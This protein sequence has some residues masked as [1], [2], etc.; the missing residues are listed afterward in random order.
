MR[1]FARFAR[2]RK[3]FVAVCLPYILVSIFAESL[4]VGRPDGSLL[5]AGGSQAVVAAAVPSSA[6]S[7]FSCPVCRWLR[8][9][10]RLEVGFGLARIEGSVPSRVDPFITE[11]PDSPVPRPSAFRGPPR[12]FLA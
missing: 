1:G 5:P 3:T 12:P 6:S 10:R 2:G 8:D 9:G 11:W 7:D 4:H